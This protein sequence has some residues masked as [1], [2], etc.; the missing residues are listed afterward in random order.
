M[1]VA[2]GGYCLAGGGQHLV[3]PD[4]DGS[5]SVI[6]LTINAEVA[7]KVSRPIPY[8]NPRKDMGHLGH[9]G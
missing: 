6:M 2:A 1:D 4:C 8:V 3:I 5:I 7:R 9:D